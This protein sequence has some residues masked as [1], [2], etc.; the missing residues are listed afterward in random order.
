[1][2]EE[3]EIV[4]LHFQLVALLYEGKSYCQPKLVQKRLPAAGVICTATAT[5]DVPLTSCS[6]FHDDDD[7]NELDD[8]HSWL[9]PLLAG[10]VSLLSEPSRRCII[11]KLRSYRQRAPPHRLNGAA[12]LRAPF[13]RREVLPDSGWSFRCRMVGGAREPARI[14][15]WRWL[16]SSLG[17]YP[18]CPSGLPKHFVRVTCSEAA[19][20]TFPFGY[21]KNIRRRCTR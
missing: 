20:R 9:R 19:Y 18:Q 5:I 17:R 7:D 15:V 14:V 12:V 4:A 16:Y 2:V 13:E 21:G 6:L 11:C 3:K 1:M 10:M 8:T